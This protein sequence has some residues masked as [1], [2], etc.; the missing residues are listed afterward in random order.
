ERGLRGGP[1]PRR[2]TRWWRGRRSPPPGPGAPRKARPSGGGARR[3]AV[4]EAAGTLLAGAVG[5]A[6]P[7]VARLHAVADDLGAAVLAQG[8]HLVDRALEGRSE[9]HTSEL[10]SRENLVCRPPLEKKHI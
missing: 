7:V 4:D 1:L 5:A 10:Q 9:E 3:H 6:V 8:R 2:A